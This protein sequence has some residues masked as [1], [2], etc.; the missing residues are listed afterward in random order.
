MLYWLS[1]LLSDSL[2]FLAVFQYLTLRGIL[3]VITAL[4]IALWVG[5]KM[6][7]KKSS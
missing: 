3:G 6:I 7:K 5:P 2:S 1:S 4:L